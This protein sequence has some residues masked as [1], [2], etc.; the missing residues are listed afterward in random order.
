MK[1]ILVLILAFLL[2]GC[3]FVIRNEDKIKIYGNPKETVLDT[4]NKID[5]AKTE[6]KRE[7]KMFKKK[8]EPQRIK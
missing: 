4:I 6:D 8:E 3:F 2:S 7:I 5:G 1:V